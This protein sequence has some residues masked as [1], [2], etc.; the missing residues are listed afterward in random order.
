MQRVL[1]AA[2]QLG[3]RAVVVDAI[4]A[5]ATSFCRRRGFEPASEDGLTLMVPIAV[6]RSQLGMHD[7]R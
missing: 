2:D 3:I 4:D 6:V 5:E 1:A 7:L